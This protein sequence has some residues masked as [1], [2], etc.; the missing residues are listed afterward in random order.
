MSFL[1][2]SF[3]RF[4]GRWNGLLTRVTMHSLP[5]LLTHQRHC[6]DTLRCAALHEGVISSLP[7]S[8]ILLIAGSH[9]CRRLTRRYRG[10]MQSNCDASPRPCTDHHVIPTPPCWLFISPLLPSPFSPS[11]LLSSSADLPRTGKTH[12]PSTPTPAPSPQPSEPF[13]TPSS[14]SNV[15]STPQDGEQA[16]VMT[17]PQLP[18]TRTRWSIEETETLRRLTDKYGR[19]WSAMKA[20]DRISQWHT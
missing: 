15:R 12:I 19:A 6:R 11:P 3:V 10:E 17:T 5:R 20:K 1:S 7:L 14:I 18:Q 9:Y 16:T 13:P 4:L 2:R 8:F